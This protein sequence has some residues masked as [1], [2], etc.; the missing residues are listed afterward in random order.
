MHMNEPYAWIRVGWRLLRYLGYRMGLGECPTLMDVYPE[1]VV[2]FDRVMG[3]PRTLFVKG[4][5]H[6][7]PAGPVVYAGNHAKKD[8]PFIMYRAV[9]RVTGWSCEIRYMMRDDFFKGLP[10]LRIVDID[11]L[12]R[13]LG[14]QQISR[15]NVQLSQLKPFVKLLRENNGFIMYPG[16]SRSRSGLFMEYRDGIDEPGGVTFFLAQAQRGHPELRVPAV[17]MARTHNPVTKRSVII[18]GPPV[19]LPHDADRTMQRD[20]D[21][22]LVERMGDLVEINV[23]MAAAAVLYLQCLHHRPLPIDQGKLVAA[24]RSALAQCSANRY[25]DETALADLPREVKVTLEYFQK[26]G[27]LELRGTVVWPNRESILFAPDLDKS[28]VRKNPVKHLVNQILHLPDVVSA[29][30]D[31]AQSL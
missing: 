15:D 28:Y 12:V 18:F 31:A 9:H 14:A 20:L 17:P 6:C 24:V 13:M 5:E 21:F 25:I 27:M 26:R 16:R 1:A 19:Y 11:E 4:G 10:N 8:D 22:Q 7:P 29:C 3:W 2:V 23:A 30:E